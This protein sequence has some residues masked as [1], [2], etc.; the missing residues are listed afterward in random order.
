MDELNLDIAPHCKDALEELKAYAEHEL[1]DSED[2]EL[3]YNK[4]E[5]ALIRFQRHYGTPT[6][7]AS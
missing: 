1:G 2:Q 7:T 4:A 5:D 3:R 6:A